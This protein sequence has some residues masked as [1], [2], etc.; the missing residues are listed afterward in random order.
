MPHPEIKNKTPF[1]FQ[2][3]FVA[4]EEMHPLLVPIIKGTFS[5]VD[6]SKL[7]IADVQEAINYSGEYW[8][9]PEESS[10]KYEPET[11][12]YKPSTDIILIG[13]AV[14]QRKSTTFLDVTLR[15]GTIQKTVRVYGERQW[16]TKMGFISKSEP[17]VFERMPLDWEHAFGGWDKSNIDPE[18]HSFEP[19][20]PVGIGFHK[21]SELMEGSK[22]P[23]LENPSELIQ[24]YKDKPTPVSFGFTS[25]H[26]QPRAN[27]AG[28]YDENW[29]KNR[30]PLLPKDFNRKFFNSAP[31]DLIAKGFLKG[32]E[33]VTIYNT[34]AGGKLSFSLPGVIPPTCDVILAG[35]RKENL[36]SNLDTIIINSDE[37]SLFII[38]RANLLLRNGP[39]DVLSIEISSESF[40]KN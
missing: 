21:T 37:N 15:V 22:L 16:F 32:N 31:Q 3:M 6:S 40:S 4:D 34:K 17:K 33:S 18:K 35:N 10:Y 28:T 1:E 13:H 20:N 30:S 25:P 27:Y 29:D 9:K 14:A 19:R 7:V 24:S 36:Q 11:A 8:G 38:W 2:P 23:N 5:I 12:F 26:W 39:Q